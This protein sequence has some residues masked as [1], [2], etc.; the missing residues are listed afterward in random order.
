MGW[1]AQGDEH[2][3]NVTSWHLLAFARARKVVTNMVLNLSDQSRVAGLRGG[4][5]A[6]RFVRR[7]GAW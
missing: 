4:W 5:L 6:G 3:E 1:V 2:K 7:F